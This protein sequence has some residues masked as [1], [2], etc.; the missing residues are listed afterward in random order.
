MT[1][2]DLKRPTNKH[3]QTNNLQK[4]TLSSKHSFGHILK[5]F[6]EN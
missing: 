1:L 3:F 6:D 5:K 4:F 2:T